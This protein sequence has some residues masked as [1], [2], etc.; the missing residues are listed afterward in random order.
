MNNIIEILY[1]KVNSNFEQIRCSIDS[2]NCVVTVD[3]H[4][5]IINTNLS[6][7]IHLLR[8]SVHG[9]LDI[10]GVKLDGTGLRSLLNLSYVE[11]NGKKMQPATCVWEPDQV[12]VLPFAN[13]FSAW[14]TEVNKHFASPHIGTRN[15]HDDFEI[16]Y[17]EPL[18]T[19]NFPKSVKDFF[20]QDFGFT[21]VKKTQSLKDLP[22]RRVKP[23]LID[24]VQAEQA[25]Q[26]IINNLD[27]FK[28]HSRALSVCRYDEID[29][30]EYND[31]QWR[32]MHFVSNKPGD[33]PE[34]GN[35]NKFRYTIDVD[36]F[37]KFFNLINKLELKNLV[38]G[39]VGITQPHRYISPHIDN[40]DYGADFWNKYWGCTQ[41]YFSLTANDQSFMKMG[42]VGILPTDQP[43]IVN[44]SQYT[45]SIINPHDSYRVYVGL[46]M[47]PEDNPQLFS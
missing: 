12:W 9:R 33:K 11:H 43:L 27:Y 46:I 37:P 15:L 34:L 20:A 14:L 8:I 41:L 2:K 3:D 36:R 10:T 23:G 40:W 16:F 39:F 47:D 38:T 25:Y 32:L 31:Y 7:G 17:P 35:E 42:N 29:D 19:E 21:A 28:N 13:P 45:H 26:E 18:E 4:S 22:Y 30:A 44:V 5:L 24:S 1:N 6:V